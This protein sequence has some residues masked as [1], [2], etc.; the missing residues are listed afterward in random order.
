MYKIIGYDCDLRDFSFTE[1][2]FVKAIQLARD[3]ELGACVVMVSCGKRS[4]RH[5]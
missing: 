1:N 4:V 5:Y 2:S 3:L